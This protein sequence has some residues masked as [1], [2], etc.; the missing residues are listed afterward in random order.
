MG[1]NGPNR[2][3]PRLKKDRHGKDEG[4]EANSPVSDSPRGYFLPGGSSWR[5]V[6]R[7]ELS[8]HPRGLAVDKYQETGALRGQRTSLKEAAEVSGWGETVMPKTMELPT[9]LSPMPSSLPNTL[10]H[11]DFPTRIAPDVYV[12]LVSLF[13]L[14][15][16]VEL[17]KEVAP[18][19]LEVE[20]PSASS[21]AGMVGR[22]D[23]KGRL[24]MFLLAHR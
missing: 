6:L 13:N 20:L 12:N 10:C 1:G 4:G 5:P 18:R 16:C 21:W 3:A 24:D 2:S 8:C 9:A 14:Q 19:S 23:T 22:E 15:S 11:G 17:H 7:P